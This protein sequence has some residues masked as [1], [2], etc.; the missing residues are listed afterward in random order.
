MTQERKTRAGAE[1]AG[2]IAGA[3]RPAGERVF[4][5]SS[6][7]P[8]PKRHRR[9]FIPRLPK[10][11]KPERE[12]G[13]S[14]MAAEQSEMVP[15]MVVE[16]TSVTGTAL[17]L[18]GFKAHLRMGTGFGEDNLQDGVLEAL[19]RA[20]I[21][22]IEGRIGKALLAR[23]FV[24]TLT[25]WRDPAAQVLPLAPVSEIAALRLFSRSGAETVVDPSAYRL[26]Q[27]MHRPLLLPTASALPTIAPGGM[28][29][30]E[31]TA[32]YSATWTGIPSDLAQAVLLLAAHYYERRNET[33]GERAVQ[34]PFGVS[35]LIERYRNL[36]LGSWGMQ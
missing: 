1:R 31:L 2:W 29:E 9:A 17:P 7:I 35:A 34:I 16:L 27:D 28:A 12:K 36:R 18:A 33:D 13:A 24:W 14:E 4:G 32:G 25:G 6:V 10:R 21:A 30:I 20:A 22:A 11:G 5:V 19:L 3:G 26:V 8:L 23:K 15:M